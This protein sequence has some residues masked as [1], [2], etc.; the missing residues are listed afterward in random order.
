MRW[1]CRLPFNRQRM[2]NLDKST[3][4]RV[5]SNNRSN[6]TRSTER[7]FRLLLARNGVTGWRLGGLDLPGSPDVV[8]PHEHL[9]VF[10]DGCFW[11]G[12]TSCRSVP[13]TNHRF[14]EQKIRG[15]QKRDRQ[16]TRRLRV[17]GWVS[18]RYWEHDLKRRKASFLLRKLEQG[19]STAAQQ[20]RRNREKKKLVS[21]SRRGD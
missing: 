6:G 4:F 10:L 5:M 8:F 13:R 2:D 21:S 15:N 16:A 20:K 18:I 17:L 3:R 9:A 1:P 12:C 14:W 11:H 7:R 19:L